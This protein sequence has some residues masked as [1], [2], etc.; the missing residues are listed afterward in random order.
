M[1]QKFV[2]GAGKMK[3]DELRFVGGYVKVNGRP[4]ICLSEFV[5]LV[6]RGVI[7]ELCANLGHL[8]DKKRT[9]LFEFFV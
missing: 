3:V 2:Y 5:R 6:F 1:T 9:F 4:R 7:T 8:R